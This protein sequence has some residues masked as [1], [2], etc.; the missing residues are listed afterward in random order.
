MDVSHYNIKLYNFIKYF[1]NDI[2]LLNYKKKKKPFI[3][4]VYQD[5]FKR[6]KTRLLDWACY[7]GETTEQAQ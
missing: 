3:C 6:D 2:I 4:S 7:V 1:S 5:S